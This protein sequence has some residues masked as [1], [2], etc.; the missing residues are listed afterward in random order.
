MERFQYVPYADITVTEPNGDRRHQRA[1]YVVAAENGYSFALFCNFY[2]FDSNTC[3]E[4]EEMFAVYG[5]D[6]AEDITAIEVGEE[7]VTDPAV[8]REIFEALLSSMCFGNDDFQEL[9]FGGLMTESKRQELSLT[10]AD[11]MVPLRITTTAGMVTNE[12]RYYP[13]IGYIMWSLNYYQLSGP[14]WD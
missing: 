5:I 6:A 11:S 4:A 13:I 9:V 1:V 10:L 3:T 14:L 7:T 12:L 8:I 2:Q